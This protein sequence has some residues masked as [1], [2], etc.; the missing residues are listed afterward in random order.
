[1]DELM[2]QKLGEYSHALL[3]SEEFKTLNSLFE[4]QV[5]VDVLMTK[6]KD[7]EERERLYAQLQGTRAFTSHIEGFAR[8]YADTL[9]T[10]LDA[11]TP[12]GDD[13]DPSCHDISP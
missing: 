3:A 12:V 13:D 7:S 9:Q 11:E 10:I 4:Q 6:P 2:I 8:A 1:V 5:A